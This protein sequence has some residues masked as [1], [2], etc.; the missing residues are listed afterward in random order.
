MTGERFPPSPEGVINSSSAVRSI[1]TQRFNGNVRSLDLSLQ[2]SNGGF[3]GTG[4][5]RGDGQPVSS[6]IPAR[7]VTNQYQTYIDYVVVKGFAFILCRR[8]DFSVASF[9][10]FGTAVLSYVILGASN[11]G[12]TL[13]A[14]LGVSSLGAIGTLLE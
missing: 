6:G 9:W 7:Q 10:K 12:T 13:I 5:P 11:L 3:G 4:F 14:W 1:N 2:D 8:L